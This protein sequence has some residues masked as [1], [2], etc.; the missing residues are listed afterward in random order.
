MKNGTKIFFA[1]LVAA[2]ALLFI[3]NKK[4]SS[5]FHKAP[6]TEPPINNGAGTG[7]TPNTNGTAPPPPTAAVVNY[8]RLL[9][10]GINDP[11]A[12][13]VLQHYLGITEDGQFGPQTETTLFNKIGEKSVTLNVYRIT[14]LGLPAI[15]DTSGDL[16]VSDFFNPFNWFNN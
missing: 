8:D 15:N 1:I 14:Q 13:K 2:L 3:F 4:I 16:S 11:A 12:V 10:K 9:Y 5:F 6:P 7:S